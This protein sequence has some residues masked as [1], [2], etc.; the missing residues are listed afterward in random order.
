MCYID[1]EPCEV[2]IETESRARK[3]HK[4][5]CCGGVIRPGEVYVRHFSKFEGT[6]SAE[7]MCKPCE[8]DRDEFA[9]AHDGMYSSPS[10]MPHLIHECIDEEPESREKWEPMLDRFKSRR[11]A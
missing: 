7:K 2:W 4:C 10:Y 8:A 11:T 3:P 5:G 6:V 1:L 9:K